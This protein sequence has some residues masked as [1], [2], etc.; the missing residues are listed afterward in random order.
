MEIVKSKGFSQIRRKWQK[1]NRSKNTES[2]PCFFVAVLV[3]FC[4][5][6]SRKVSFG[7]LPG[8]LIIINPDPGKKQ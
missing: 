7:I 3:D 2:G 4:S 5:K 6:R 1:K 8:C